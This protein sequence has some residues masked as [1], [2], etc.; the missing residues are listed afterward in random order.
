M[1]T[2]FFV[3]SGFLITHV[4]LN[5]AQPKG[6]ISISRFYIKR[7][8][9]ILPVYWL[10]LFLSL[11]FLPAILGVHLPAPYPKLADKTQGS[12]W[13]SLPLYLLLAPNLAYLLH[14]R[15]LALS[16]LWSVGVEEQSYLIWP[17]LLRFAGGRKTLGGLLVALIGIKTFLRLLPAHSIFL[18][19]LSQFEIES[20]AMG[21]LGALWVASATRPG[22]RFVSSTLWTWICLFLI[23]DGIGFLSVSLPVIGWSALSILICLHFATRSRPSILDRPLL[24]RL[25]KISYG[26]YMYH[27]AVVLAS[28][29]I[30]HSMRC[31]GTNALYVLPLLGTILA[32]EASYRWV[33]LP[34]RRMRDRVLASMPPKDQPQF[35]AITFNN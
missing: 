30:L 27:P 35:S 26:I 22:N 6:W 31:T 14:G 25:G 28:I 9:R 10:I 24:S 12:F 2:F 8:F 5:E 11:L 18:K 21:G 13:S 34:S 7:A 23:F 20:F 4:L 33:E 17:W 29:A 3:L 19:Y 32:A 15:R 1:V 16:H